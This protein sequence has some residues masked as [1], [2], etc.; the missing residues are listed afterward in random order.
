MKDLSLLTIQSCPRCAI[1]QALRTR[2]SSCSTPNEP[3]ASATPSAIPEAGEPSRSQASFWQISRCFVNGIVPA[4]S[5]LSGDH[6]FSLVVGARWLSDGRSSRQNCPISQGLFPRP[7]LHP[8]N[9]TREGGGLATRWI[10]S[11]DQAQ[12]LYR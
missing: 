6:R 9:E 8:C 12:L 5:G 4:G 1:S 10:A 2:S 11:P 7:G 3:P